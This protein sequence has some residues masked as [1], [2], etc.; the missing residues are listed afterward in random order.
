MRRVENP[1]N[2][3]ERYSSEY[4]GEAPRA[5]LEVYEE[6]ITG[7]VI[8]SSFD[9]TSRDRLTV[10]C[11]R[12]CIHACTYC[13]ARRYHEFLGYGAGTDFE[14]K[15]VAKINA[16]EVLRRELKT[17]RRKIRKLE[18]S[19]ATDPYIPIEATYQLT[20]RCLETCAEFGIRA[21][22]VTK[23]PLVTRDIDVLKRMNAV[24][25]F[26]IPFADTKSS[27]PFEL[28][29]PIP[30]AR[31]RAMKTV[32][33]AGIPTGLALAPV[34]PGIN[35]SQIPTLLETARENGASYAFM[36]LLHIDSESIAEYFIAKTRELVPTK[37]G[38]VINALKRERGGKLIH[39][40]F[41]ERENGRTEQWN[42]ARK[43]FDMHFARLGYKEFMR[44]EEEP[45]E[46]PIAV[47]GRLF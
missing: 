23:S 42:A 46:K 12:G 29:A 2:P 9:G 37:V 38:R 41:A 32:S 28:Y 39:G 30:E 17:T 47:Q 18:F 16:P 3:Y 45:V 36:S 43:L 34:I 14:T 5:R 4:L 27:K 26:S 19:F 35:D 24:V 6:T 7:T 10:N 40:T 22:I 15:I 13:F 11:Y 20:R 33:D 44:R 8:S 1:E 21:I 31:F 25:C